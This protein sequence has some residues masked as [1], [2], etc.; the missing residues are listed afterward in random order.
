MQNKNNIGEGLE[1]AYDTLIPENDQNRHVVVIVT[2]DGPSD[3]D[4]ETIA[5]DIKEEHIKMKGVQ[6]LT[7]H[8]AE[9]LGTYNMYLCWIDI[10]AR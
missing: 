4:V 7:F 10:A 3:D 1:E 6:R 2:T 9:Q 8:N 5:D